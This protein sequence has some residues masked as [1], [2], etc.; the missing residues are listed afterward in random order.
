MSIDGLAVVEHDVAQQNAQGLGVAESAARGERLAE[1]RRDVQALENGVD[2]RKCHFVEQRRNLVL[3]G[4]TGIGK[5]HIAKA[6]GHEVCRRG[7]DVVFR[8]THSLLGELLDRTSPR[9][10]ER[11]LN[12]CLKVELLILDDFAFR[13]LDHKEAELLYTL[14]EE[15]GGRASTILTSNRPPQ[16]W[17][18]ILPDP[19]MGS[20]ILDRLVSGAVKLIV[21]KGR[22]YRREGPSGDPS[23][24]THPIEVG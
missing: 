12:R 10:A 21:T 23:L 9:H 11:L 13:T 14:A 17:Y 1:Q 24:L 18:A 4:P 2:Q 7:F 8:K 3:A 15:R 20:A 16:D 19:V 5:T 22:S 6:I